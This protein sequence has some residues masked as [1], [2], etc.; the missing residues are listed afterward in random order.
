MPTNEYQCFQL[1]VPDEGLSILIGMGYKENSAKRA[2]R[3]TGNDIQAAVQFLIEEQD[4]KIRREQE[5]L[6]RQ[7]EIKYNSIPV[8]RSLLFY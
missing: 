3:M 7:V 8:H 4:K 2:L 5:N 1:Q 6:E